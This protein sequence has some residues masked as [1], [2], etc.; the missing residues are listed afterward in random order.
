LDTATGSDYITHSASAKL[1][2]TFY[3]LFWST[4]SPSALSI[5]CMYAQ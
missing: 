1:G 2:W 4:S 3:N 5:N